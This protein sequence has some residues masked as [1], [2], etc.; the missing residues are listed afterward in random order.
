MADYLSDRNIGPPKYRDKVRSAAHPVAFSGIPGFFMPVRAGKD[1]R[2]V[3]VLFLSPWGID[4]LSTRRFFRILAE[5][6]AAIG[7]ASLRFDYPGTG[8]AL[9]ADDEMI[10]VDCWIDAAR[11]GTETLRALS[12]ARHVVL[13]GFGLGAAIACKAG[14][15]MEDVAG[16]ALLAPV[17]TGKRYLRELSVWSKIIDEGVGVP[18]HRRDTSPGTIA[19]LTM[20]RGIVSTLDTLKPEALAASS[21]ERVFFASRP[22]SAFDRM[23]RDKLEQNGA[24]LHDCAI[25]EYDRLVENPHGQR[26]PHALMAELLEWIDSLPQA[27]RSTGSPPASPSTLAVLDDEMI[28]ETGLRFG[29]DARLIGTLCEPRSDPADVTVVLLTT[30]YDHQAG[31]GR[32][33]VELARRLA[34]KGIAS[35]RFD[36]AGVGDSPPV[37]GRRLQVLYD[38]AQIADIA[39]ARSFLD[40]IGRRGPA[41]LYG[42]CSGAYVAF[43]AAAEDERWAGC[44][45]VNPYIFRWLGTPPEEVARSA[46]RPLTD[47]SQKAFRTESFRRLARGD[48][49]IRAAVRHIGA[50][51]A[52][53]LSNLLAP[54]LGPLMPIERLNRAVHADFRS[55]STRWGGTRIVYSAGDVGLDNL[56]VH[57]GKNARKLSRYPNTELH[58]LK[59]TDHNITPRASRD[60]LFDIVEQTA[61][62]VASKFTAEKA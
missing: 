6:L 24:Q 30:A 58:I 59:D 54:V 22:D 20:P 27:Q 56:H 2:D 44:I 40:E 5:D 51:L 10:D 11:R 13:L 42:R 31:W 25:P 61:L 38:D 47:Y 45:A 23:L 41:L 35:L 53:R 26:L 60:I 34:A 16:L 43:R 29:P 14:K 62:N 50:R 21:V 36:S 7:I 49:D 4:E 48:I 9:D 33:S 37:A 55:L 28:R 1:A 12:G 46:P 8:N 52:Q 18:A 57:F 17:A 15:S 32:S 3:V 39:I 19:G